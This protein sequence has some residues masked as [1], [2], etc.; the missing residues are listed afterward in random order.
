[1]ILLALASY[2]RA[3]RF[4]VVVC[5]C[6]RTPASLYMTRENNWGLGNKTRRKCGTICAGS[7]DAV[8]FVDKVTSDNK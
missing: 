6:A 4:L 8:G 3:S 5:T 2:V 7:W 1:M